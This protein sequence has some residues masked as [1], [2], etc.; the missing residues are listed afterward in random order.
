ML[1]HKGR[2]DPGLSGNPGAVG[3]IL[4]EQLSDERAEVHIRGEHHDDLCRVL[5]YSLNDALDVFWGT[6]LSNERGMTQ[7]PVTM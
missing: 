6:H 7:M 1:H 4:S 3:H 2:C 5:D